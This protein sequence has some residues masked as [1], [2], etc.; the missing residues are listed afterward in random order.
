[1]YILLLVSQSAC[2]YTF[3]LVA[4]CFLLIHL[5]YVSVTTEHGALQINRLASVEPRAEQPEPGVHAGE[6]GLAWR[7]S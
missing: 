1:M 2:I 5:C 6:T 4:T 7:G 3:A